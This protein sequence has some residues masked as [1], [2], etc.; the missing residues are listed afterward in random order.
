MAAGEA[1]WFGSRRRGPGRPGS[2]RRGAPGPHVVPGAEDLW[3]GAPPRGR[4]E[5]GAGRGRA[6][7]GR[8]YGTVQPLVPAS[9]SPPRRARGDPL[10]RVLGCTVHYSRPRWRTSTSRRTASRCAP[11]CQDGQGVSVSV[12]QLGLQLRFSF[13]SFLGIR[14]LTEMNEYNP[15]LFFS[16]HFCDFHLVKHL[17]SAA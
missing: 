1:K 7:R 8:S 3:W 15:R 17:R 5:R 16:S 14:F 11:I 10:R 6:R 12:F 2:G 9:P 4:W 13:Y